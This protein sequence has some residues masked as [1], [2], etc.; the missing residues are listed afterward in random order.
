M[1]GHSCGPYPSMESGPPRVLRMWRTLHPCAMGW[2]ELA[3]DCDNTKHNLPTHS[4]RLSINAVARPRLQP[5]LEGRPKPTPGNRTETTVATS[6]LLSVHGA[7]L[8]L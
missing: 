8:E 3:A 6:S 1:S 7:R 5:A 2:P 4:R